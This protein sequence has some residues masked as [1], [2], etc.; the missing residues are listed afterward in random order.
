MGS[1]Q[2]SN[3]WAVSF[4]FSSVTEPHSQADLI[5]GRPAERGKFRVNAFGLVDF[6]HNCHRFPEPPSTISLLVRLELLVICLIRFLVSFAG[7]LC[8]VYIKALLYFAF[9]MHTDAPPRPQTDIEPLEL[10]HEGNLQKTDIINNKKN[11][12]FWP[13]S[14]I[15]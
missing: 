7:D 3:W 9:P 10:G 12:V 11:F 14:N 13:C 1:V 4:Q 6:D 5:Y 15:F 8:M 2:P